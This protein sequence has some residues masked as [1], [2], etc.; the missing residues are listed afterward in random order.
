MVVYTCNPSTWEV[1][2]GEAGVQ[3]Q[4]WLCCELGGQPGLHEI[5]I[6]KIKNKNTTKKHKEKE[7]EEE[8]KKEEGERGGGGERNNKVRPT[9]KFFKILELDP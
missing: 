3:G 2:V 9:G 6:S 4:P 1:V 7:N 8:K 5:Q